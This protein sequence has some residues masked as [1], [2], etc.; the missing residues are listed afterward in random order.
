MPPKH[1]IKCKLEPEEEQ[2]VRDHMALKSCVRCDDPM[3]TGYTCTKAK[4]AG[5]NGWYA[6]LGLREKKTCVDMLMSRLQAELKAAIVDPAVQ[7]NPTPE[8]HA[9][10]TPQ[11]PTDENPDNATSGK[12]E[13]WQA[14]ESADTGRVL[15]PGREE[16]T[17]DVVK[18]SLGKAT[19]G[20]IP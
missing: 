8:T 16:I 5:V 6:N 15:E 7:S 13:F 18:S 14:Q 9:D 3:H 20:E 10:T 19:E 1:R 4:W 17:N 12:G 2:Y 11:P